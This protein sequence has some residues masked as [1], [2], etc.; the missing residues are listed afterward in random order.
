MLERISINLQIQRSIVPTAVTLPQFKVSG[1]LP[2]LQANISDTKYKSLMRLIDVAIPVF[3]KKVPSD[4]TLRSSKGLSTNFQLPTF[5][6]RGDQEYHVDDEDGGDP[7]KVESKIQDD[8]PDGS[9]QVKCPGIMRSVSQKPFH[10][11]QQ[12]IFELDFKVDN[13][14]AVI[15]KSTKDGSDKVVGDLHLE[16]FLLAFSMTD[17]VMKADLNLR[18]VFSSPNNST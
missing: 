4:I 18:S 16:G 5:F 13:L 3:D 1:T 17:F 6:G 10:A 12:H 9:L 8:P 15:S 11:L 14:R 2:S 7:P